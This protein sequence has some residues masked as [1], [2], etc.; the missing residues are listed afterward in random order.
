VAKTEYDNSAAVRFTIPAQEQTKARGY[1]IALFESLKHGKTRLLA[2]DPVAALAENAVS[3]AT[4]ARAPIALKK[5]V[6][7]YFVLYGDDLGPVPT[8]SGSFPPANN[9]L[10]GSPT[11][12]TPIATPSAI[13]SITPAPTPTPL[14]H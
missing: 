3:P 7:Y 9:R 13:P 6:G 12:G 11:P 4:A 14:P 5:N 10:L 8:P 1:T 2:W